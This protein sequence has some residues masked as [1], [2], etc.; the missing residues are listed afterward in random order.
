MNYQ[1]AKTYKPYGKQLAFHNAGAKHRERLLVAGNQLGKTFC[2]G[3]ET[4]MHLTGEYPEWWSGKRF[5]RPIRCWSAGVS[6]KATRERVQTMLMGSETD[7]GTG[8]IPRSA[9]L[10][11]PVMNRSISGMIDYVLIKHKTGGESRLVFKSYEMKLETWA[12]DEIDLVWLDEEPPEKLF[13]ECLARVTNTKGHIIITFTPLL[14]MSTVVRHFYPECDTSQRWMVRM[15][16]EDA[17]HISA[18]ERAII[19]ARYPE[20]EREARTR[21]IPTMGS[22]R[23]FVHLESFISEE[24]FEIPRHFARLN[25]VDLGYG[26]HP[27]AV[28]FGAFDRDANVIHVYDTYC[29]KDPRLAIHADA[30]KGKPH[31]IPTTYPHDAGKHDPGSGITYA[32]MYRQK[33]VKMTSE[34]ATFVDGGFRVEP[35]IQMMDERFAAGQLKIFRH[36]HDWFSEYRTYHR[37]EGIIVDIRDDLL[38][39]TRLLVMM[40]RAFRT[41]PAE[42]RQTQA[43]PYDVL[44]PYPHA[45]RH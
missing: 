25:A 30:I 28:V 40:A 22:G 45:F 11:P 34:H 23:V 37:K 10:S 21:G 41:E 7:W 38:C 42:T 20:H 32:D 36:L 1:R 24:P 5:D 43:I 6:N 14:G 15:E 27:T 13:N 9:L 4:A 17:L 18:E 33:G 31:W 44:D 39:A 2:G 8:M 35:G 29:N 19:I 3:Y 12:S 26:D 16:I